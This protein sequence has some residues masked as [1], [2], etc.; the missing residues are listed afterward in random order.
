VTIIV[1]VVVAGNG[2]CRVLNWSAI[3]F[4]TV[5]GVGRKVVL[6]KVALVF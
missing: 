1:T 2:D 3:L 4:S 6:P 5:S